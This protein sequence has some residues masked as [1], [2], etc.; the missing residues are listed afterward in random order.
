MKTQELG[1]RNT[2]TIYKYAGGK[3]QVLACFH[4]LITAQ[5]K[6]QMA[7][8][9]GLRIH[10]IWF[11][12]GSAEPAESDTALTRPKWTFGFNSSNII[13]T[14]RPSLSQDG[15]WNILCT[16]R[17][18]ASSSYVGTVS[19]IGLYVVTNG[20]I[21]FMGAHALI[22]DAEGNPMTITKTETEVLYV[23]IHIQYRN[24]SSSGF[25]W[26][27][28][29]YYLLGEKSSS[30]GSWL[31][32][33]SSMQIA[34]F[35]AYPDLMSNGNLIGSCVLLTHSY[36]ESRKV[37]SCSNGRFGTQNQTVTDY[38]NAIGVI[39]AF[40]GKTTYD[41]SRPNVPIGYWKFP[42][43]DI[44]PNA[45]LSDMRVGTG[46]GSTADFRAPLGL[47][48]KDTE[49][50]YVDGVLQVRDVDYTCDHRNNAGN[51]YSLNPSMF[52][53]LKNELV[54]IDSPATTGMGYHPL[55]GYGNDVSSSQN[56]ERRIYIL[57]D[58]DHPLEWELEPDPQIGIEADYFQMRDIQNT[59]SNYWRN[60]VF[61]L[62]YSE[63]GEAWTQVGSYTVT[64]TSVAAA[65]YRFIFPER[66]EAA[67]WRLSTDV[68]GCSEA[69][70]N[71]RFFSEGI[72]Y[73]HRNGDPIHFTN[74]PADGAVITM[75]AQIDR[76]MKNENFILD[77]NPTFQL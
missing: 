55:K 45:T 71:G 58:K 52:C 59:G 1:M 74:P 72:S 49:R 33:L 22:K 62:S 3:K 26:S 77:V 46:D 31:P 23:D 18:A 67:H 64:S 54:R 68:S 15:T 75:T 34:M 10:S 11:G 12:D 4:N 25:E 65:S 6:K 40:W 14:E 30:A 63:D 7:S 38:V 76:P 43:P 21:L 35:R 27:P 66:I 5:M 53:H 13:S 16:A 44:F 50:I 2:Y 32:V 70:R 8:D 60:A 17:I 48:V 73:L 41:S 29:Y 42:D 19:E 39:P 61:T 36:D 9:V 57:W 20:S 37:L 47:W 24:S 69:V 51:L 28:W 56:I